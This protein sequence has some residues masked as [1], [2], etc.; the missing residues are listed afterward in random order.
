MTSPA[1]KTSKLL[2]T[3]C[4]VCSEMFLYYLRSTGTYC[5]V[6][7]LNWQGESSLTTAQ[8]CSDCTLGVDSMELSSPFGYDDNLASNFQSLTS[9]CSAAGYAFS[10]PS[11]IALNNTPTLTTPGSVSAAP[12]PSCI[13][14]YTVVNG[15]DC[16]SVAAANNVSTGNL[17]TANDL[18]IN[19][20]NFPVVGTK[21]C[22]PAQCD[23]YILRGSDT[24]QSILSNLNG[25]T[26]TQLFSW[27]PNINA[28]CGNINRLVGSVICTRQETPNSYLFEILV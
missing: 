22:I 25:T 4:I 9:S 12:T 1:G 8:N 14:F 24:C 13:S 18:N 21:L 3:K 5:G 17:L 28:V 23:T 10:S 26:L 15:D 19:C 11:N 6:E 27:N 7:F 16:N 2:W 20:E